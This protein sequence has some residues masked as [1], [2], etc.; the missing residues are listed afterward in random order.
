MLNRTMLQFSLCLCNAVKHT[1][2]LF[3]DTPK[4]TFTSFG[5]PTATGCLTNCRYKMPR[6][7]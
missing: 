3:A 5:Q 6:C 2:V 1:A 4:E 7:C